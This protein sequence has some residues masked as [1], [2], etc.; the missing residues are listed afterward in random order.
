MIQGAIFDA[1]GTLLDSMFIW[2]TIGED[3][4]RSLGYTPRE[5][6]N[7][8]F[9]NMSLYQAACYYRSEYGVE[10]SVEEI[11]DGVN[12]KIEGL[13]R[14]KVPL[15]PGVR[16]FLGQLAEA[17]VKMCVAT[18]TDLPLI[19]AALERG[20]V[21]GYFSHILTCGQIGHGKDEPV[22]YQ[23]ALARLGTERPRTVVFEDSLYAVRTAKA[24]GFPVAGVYDEHEER[25]GEVQ[26]LAGV[27]LRDFSQ[28]DSFWKFASAL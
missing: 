22:I 21:S 27:Y 13:Y 25:T 7:E 23:E 5:N 8:T 26:A 11:I 3:Y 2:D 6:L 24:A 14:H 20:G 28:L 10:L 12:G 16:E 9:K 19:R 4:L 15:K 17:G 1:D 18:A